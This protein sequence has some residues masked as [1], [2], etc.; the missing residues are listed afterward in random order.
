MK[1]QVG[2]RWLANAAHI[3]CQILLAF[4]MHIRNCWTNVRYIRYMLQILI[5]LAWLRKIRNGPS[6][7]LIKNVT[8]VTKNVIIHNAFSPNCVWSIWFQW[9]KWYY[10]RIKFANTCPQ[11]WQ[12]TYDNRDTTYHWWLLRIIRTR[13]RYIYVLTT[14]YLFELAET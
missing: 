4:K 5:C 14:A 8:L 12:E 1:G 6:K 11:K 13:C 2:N 7:L 9:T 3:A 10:I